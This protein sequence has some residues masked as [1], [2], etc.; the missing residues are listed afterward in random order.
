MKPRPSVGRRAISRRRC[1]TCSP[2]RGKFDYKLNHLKAKI[3]PL[4]S[5]EGDIF[6]KVMLGAEA[7]L[8]S[9]LS[10][11]DISTPAALHR[12]EREMNEAI[13]SDLK[14]ALEK[15]QAAGADILELGQRLEWRYPRLWAR[16]K[17]KWMQVYGKE[18]RFK[19]KTDIRVTH[20]EGGA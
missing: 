1:T 17:N 16:L 8:E 18:V 13:G 5:P 15:S 2:A 9:A 14:S 7:T 12:L 19:V 6:C 4:V 11:E 20:M 10:G 3:T